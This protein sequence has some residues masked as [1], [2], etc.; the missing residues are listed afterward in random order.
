MSDRLP[1]NKSE[2]QDHLRDAWAQLQQTLDALTEEQMTERTG[3]VGWTVKDH[4]A[5]L[6]TWEQGIIALLRHEPRYPAMGTDLE[7]VRDKNEDALNEIL[8]APSESTAAAEVRDGLR[9]THE[10]FVEVVDSVE[11]DDLLKTYSHYQ[12]DELGEDSGEP[13]LR[14]VIGNSSGHYLEHLPWIRALSGEGD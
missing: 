9:Q 11:P 6:V 1:A 14:W 4:L 8:R 7:T 2:F 3:A 10:A 12:P 13:V 5:H